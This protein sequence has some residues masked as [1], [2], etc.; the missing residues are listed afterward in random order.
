MLVLGK[1]VSFEQSLN[2]C[3]AAYEWA[4]GLGHFFTKG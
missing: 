1:A 4:T 2:P 3:T